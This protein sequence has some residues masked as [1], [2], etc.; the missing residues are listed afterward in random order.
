MNLQYDSNGYLVSGF[1]KINIPTFIENFV[2][3][4]PT[5]KTRREIFEGYCKYCRILSTFN[6]VNKQ[7]INGSY[8]TKKLDPNDIDIVYIVD[9]KAIDSNKFLISYIKKL[10]SDYDT[11]WEKYKCDTHFIT[12]YPEGDYRRMMFEKS[13]AF[14]TDVKEGKYTNDR[15][16]VSKGIVELEFI[17]SF[18]NQEL[19]MEQEIKDDK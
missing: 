16:D 19:V 8:V 2:D 18:F 1:H 15:Y 11:V 4:Y 6:F 7:W 3:S 17:P 12:E 14:W 10:K 13:A 9:S 5:S